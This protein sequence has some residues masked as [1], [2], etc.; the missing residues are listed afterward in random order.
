MFLCEGLSL[1]YD[2]FV[3]ARV[4]EIRQE[5]YDDRSAILKAYGLTGS[6]V[7]WVGVIMAI[8]FLGLLFSSLV[9]LNQVHARVCKR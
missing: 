7:T 1:D 3:T 2:V 4:L 8:A 6:I 5:G 9:Q